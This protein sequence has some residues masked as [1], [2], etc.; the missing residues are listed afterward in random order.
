M[1]RAAPQVPTAA[2]VVP[3]LVVPYALDTND[4]RFATA[5]GFNTGADFCAYLTDA[6]DALYDEGA[7]GSPKL[8]SVGMHCRLLG[9]PGRLRG[10]QRFLDHVQAREG[11]WVCR[12]V[13]VAE[14]W[15]S[16]FPP[17]PPSPQ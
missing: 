15:L 4:F 14:H 1:P 12:R 8:L 7:A 13:D 10:L 3:H 16:T 17:P 6:F 11:V 5:Q 2:G 9:R